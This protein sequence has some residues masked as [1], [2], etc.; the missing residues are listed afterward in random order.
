MALRF[1]VSPDDIWR[2]DTPATWWRGLVMPVTT[3]EYARLQAAAFLP[4]AA[5]AGADTETS[6]SR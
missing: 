1:R 5:P 6:D 3:E 4:N 2:P